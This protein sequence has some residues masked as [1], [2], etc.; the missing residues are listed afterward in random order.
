M[1]EVARGLPYS[2]EVI[3]IFP[4]DEIL[5][6]PHRVDSFAVNMFDN[7]FFFSLDFDWEWTNIIRGIF[8]TSEIYYRDNSWIF[9]PL[10]SAIRYDNDDNFSMIRS[11]MPVGASLYIYD[12]DGL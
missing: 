1:I 6:T 11:D 9:D 8:E 3:V 4:F 10:G 5:F 2:L 12:I 7:I